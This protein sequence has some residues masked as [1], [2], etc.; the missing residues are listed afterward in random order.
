V[1]IISPSYCIDEK[2]LV[3]AR[4]FLEKWGLKVHIGRN[5]S[6]RDGPF[7]GSDAERLSDLQEMTDDHDI[8]AVF[9]QEALWTSRIIDKVDF[10]R[11]W[12]LINNGI[13]VLA[14]S[15]FFTCG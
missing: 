3:E 5:A 12:I 2:I 11:F 9:A 13:R 14:I 4:K 7:A 8:K 10:F 6:G 15:Q 1:A